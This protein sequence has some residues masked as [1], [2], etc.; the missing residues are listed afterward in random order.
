MRFARLAMLVTVL[1]AVTANQAMAESNWSFKKLI[2]S[3][4]KKEAPPRGLYPASNEPSLWRKMNNGTKSFF[5]KT[6]QAVPPWLMP[7]TQDRVRRS[8]ENA[9]NSSKKMREEA[10]LAKRS[11]FSP[12]SQPAEPDN[13]PE[14]VQDWIAQ[15]KP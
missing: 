5:A 9:K 14:T 7:E 1:F 6:K 8:S 4:G 10:R 13:R 2:P 12:W 15:P 11:I 3:F